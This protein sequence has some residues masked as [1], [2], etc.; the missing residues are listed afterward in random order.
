ML[1]ILQLA[2]TQPFPQTGVGSIWLPGCISL[3]KSFG[4]PR[5]PQAGLDI[6][7]IYSKL[8]FKL[9]IVHAS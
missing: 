7:S 3:V 5:Q 9:V 4:L 6:D 1:P 8:M 2:A